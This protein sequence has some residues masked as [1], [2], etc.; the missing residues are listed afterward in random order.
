VAWGPRK[1]GKSTLLKQKFKN[2]LVYDFLRT[3]LFFDFLKR[4]SLLREQL[5][6]NGDIALK[7]PIILDEVQ[8]IPQILDEVQ[9]LIE[10]KGHSFIL[11]GSSARKLKRGS[12]CR[13]IGQKYTSLFEVL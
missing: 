7:Y 10:N 4:P 2:S 6:A 13:R 9:W 12:F 5:E 11:C 3:D 1:K 8:K